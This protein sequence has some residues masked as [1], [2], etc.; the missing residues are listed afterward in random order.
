MALMLGFLWTHFLLHCL[1]TFQSLYMH[2]TD[3]KVNYNNKVRLSRLRVL[4]SFDLIDDDQ[5]DQRHLELIILTAFTLKFYFQSF[6]SKVLA[7]LFYLCRH[8]ACTYHELMICFGL[9]L[10]HSYLLSYVVFARNLM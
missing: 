9:S 2:L 1:V 3:K 6:S 10:P 4:S 5:I 7:S 8:V